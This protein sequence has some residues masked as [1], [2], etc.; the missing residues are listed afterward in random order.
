MSKNNSREKN[1]KMR[2]EMRVGTTI[3]VWGILFALIF[4]VSLGVDANN[5]VPIIISALIAGVLVTGFI[6]N[7]GRGDLS[8]DALDAVLNTQSSRDDVEFEK[9]KRD[10][11]SQALSQLSDSQ[12]AALRDGIHN[13][14][15]DD[16]RLRYMID[17]E[18]E[19][20]ERFE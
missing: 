9:R 13:G 5:L 11:L 7:W 12:L 10:R 19:L 17:D 8:Q 3:P 2:Y 18:G 6:W 15:L 1:E 4:W 14:T 16:E 20:I